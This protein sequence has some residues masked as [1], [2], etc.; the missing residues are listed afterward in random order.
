MYCSSSA[1][2]KS[3]PG[4]RWLGCQTHS[5]SRQRPSTWRRRIPSWLCN[6]D[7]SPLGSLSCPGSPSAKEARRRGAGHRRSL[8]KISA[9]KS[10]GNIDKK[11]KKMSLHLAEPAASDYVCQH[12]IVVLISML[13]EGKKMFST[14]RI[15]N[16]F[17]GFCLTGV[18][19]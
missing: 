5:S 19:T 4:S 8:C 15:V 10:K 11:F 1:F 9:K 12:R 16:M 6:F 17:G 13:R 2:M 3:A 18:L 7:S 14:Q